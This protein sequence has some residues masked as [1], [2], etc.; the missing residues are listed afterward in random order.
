MAAVHGLAFPFRN[1]L[2]LAILTAQAFRNTEIN[3]RQLQRTAN[4]SNQLWFDTLQIFFT[5]TAESE[6][7]RHIHLNNGK[8]FV[9]FPRARITSTQNSRLKNTSSQPVANGRP[10]R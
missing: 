2:F 4:Y 7:T 6:F 1:Q 8:I 9:T 5:A 10:H 3:L